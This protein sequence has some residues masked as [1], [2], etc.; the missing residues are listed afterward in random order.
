[1]KTLSTTC[2]LPVMVGFGG[3][4]SAGRASFNHAYR[5]LVIDK[6]GQQKQDATFASL[7]KLM[8]LDGNS[9]DSTVRQHIKDHTLIRKIEIFDPDAVHW[10]SSATLK[11][12]DAKSIS[13]KIPTKQLPETIPNNWSLTRINDKETQ[14]VCAESLNV[15]LPDERIS[16]VWTTTKELIG[17]LL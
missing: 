5:R 7:A 6:L 8:R 2:P 12:T 11:D 13:F 9:Q 14:I 15:L 4:N 3:V 16:K 10:Q 1:M 17:M